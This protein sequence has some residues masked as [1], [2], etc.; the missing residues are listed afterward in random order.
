[1]FASTLE[2]DRDHLPS[3]RVKGVGHPK[4]TEI[5]AARSRTMHYLSESLPTTPSIGCS[6]CWTRAPLRMPSWT[7]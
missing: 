7:G 1:M 3:Q 2:K 6:G 5:L 4:E